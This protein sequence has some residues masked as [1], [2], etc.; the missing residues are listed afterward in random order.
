MFWQRVHCGGEVILS[1]CFTFFRLAVLVARRFEQIAS[2][3]T[4]DSGDV[5]ATAEIE[6]ILAPLDDMTREFPR[7]KTATR[8]IRRFTKVSFVA[9][10]LLM[11]GSI[12]AMA[13]SLRFPNW[14]S[15][16]SR[17]T[18]SFFD[19]VAVFTL[20]SV[21]VLLCAQTQRLYRGVQ[22]RSITQELRAIGKA[23]VLATLI[24]AMFIVV[25]DRHDI[26]RLVLAGVSVGS[27]LSMAS[28]RILRRRRIS[29]MIAAGFGGRHVLV[30][31]AG[32]VGSA[33]ASYLTENKQLGYI[34]EGFVDRRHTV[35]AN[36]APEQEGQIPIVGSIEDLPTLVRKHFID[37]IF[38][39]VPSNRELVKSVALHARAAGISVRVVP[40]LYD[41]L[42]IGAP[43][44]TVGAFPTVALHHEPIA[45][46]ELFLKRVVD[47]MASM[48]GMLAIA[49]VLAAIAVLVKLD[50]RGPVIYRSVRVGKKGK[51][52]TCYK[53]RT[54]VSNAEQLK[55][56][57]RHM[58]E[59]T[60]IL[61]K[62][63]NDPRITRVG[64]LLRKYSLDELPQLMNVLKG[65]MS[66]VG[67]RPPIPSEFKQY[68]L[69]HLR[70]LD[71]TPGVTGL[72]QVE[73]RRD[74]SFDNYIKFDVHYVEN[75]SIWLDIKILFKTFAVVFAGTGQ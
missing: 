24:I 28:W 54:M 43:I 26:S 30:V 49:P 21:L 3:T 57:L 42:A 75:W 14:A 5:L 71:V 6:R 51:T 13:V 29:K 15:D 33:L 46:T 64:R 34:V 56:S 8:D 50:S 65:D 70:R 17:L 59:R 12:S 10:D 18:R 2:G 72:W 68:S 73:A 39:T 47:V 36:D 40:D 4:K 66:L 60:D 16:P 22:W 35:R 38:I 19:H 1:Q 32:R 53:F 58:N 52:F 9:T 63:S 25:S 23:T 27:A 31:G 44:E 48:A 61:F 20:Y 74:P 41:G 69:E 7:A 55:E 11:V 67:P 62:I 45:T 37:E